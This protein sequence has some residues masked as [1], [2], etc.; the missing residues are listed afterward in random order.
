MI[1]LDHLP[2]GDYTVVEKQAKDGYRLD[3]TVQTVNVEAG[4]TRKLTF[5]NEPL[6]GLLL[7]KMDS[8][9]KEPLSDVISA[10]SMRTDDGRHD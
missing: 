2:S 3:S 10:S 8:K 4:K 1:Q 6:G 5:E 9:T 7:K